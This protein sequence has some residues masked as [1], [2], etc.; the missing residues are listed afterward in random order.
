MFCGR[1]G[2]ESAIN[3]R[4]YTMAGLKEAVRKAGFEIERAVM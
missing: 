4:R 3:R 2:R 1:A